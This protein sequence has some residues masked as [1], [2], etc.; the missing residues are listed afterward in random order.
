MSGKSSYQKQ[1]GRSDADIGS[2]TQKTEGRVNLTY[3]LL[4]VVY[5]GT[6]Y[7]FYLW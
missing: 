3:V 6:P 4:T 2:Q 1:D 7:D 5:L